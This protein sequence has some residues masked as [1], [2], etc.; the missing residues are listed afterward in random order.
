MT[1][2]IRKNIMLIE[3]IILD[4]SFKD[5]QQKFS[6]SAPSEEVKQYLD[7]FKELAKRNII[8]GQ[9][10]DI[11][12][13]IKGDWESFKEFVDVNSNVVSKRQTKA[14]QKKDSIVVHSDSEKQVVIPLT[15]EASIQYGKHTKWCT[16]AIKSKNYFIDYFY[17]NKITLFYVLF[18]D[19]DKYACAFHP[20]KPDTIECFDQQDKSMSFGKFEEATG[21]S[22]K[23]IQNWYNSNKT[24]IEDSRDLNNATE[25]VQLY[26]VNQN[27]LAFEHIDNP[28]EKVQLAAVNQDGSAIRHIYEKGI[29]PS[30]E[31]QLAAVN[32]D[33]SAIEHIDNPSEELQLA[34]VNQSGDAIQEIFDKGIVPSEKVQIAA[35]SQSRYAIMH[36]DNPSEQ[37]Q[38]SAVS[39]FGRAIEYI[40]NPSE[41]IQL[42][43][44]NQNGFA[45]MHI[46]AKGIVPSEEVQLAA[47]SQD[48]RA[49]EDIDNP[50]EEVQLAVVNKSKFAAKY[51]NNPTEK[52]KALHKKLWG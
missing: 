10:K 2:D 8:K 1:S 22:K 16:S 25:E 12:K 31:V 15:K 21:I 13:W 37:V 32:Q 9:D 17:A 40:S 49:I 4:E 44:V 41:K 14:T 20:D 46:I 7:T 35:V 3:S 45:I 47:V 23:D 38:I 26:T 28:T 50:T 52:V 6:T 36:I 24:K 33:G 5:A 29:V 39:Q 11:G 27:G 43:A 34:A 42:A 51:I 48:G 18:K 30:E 19:G